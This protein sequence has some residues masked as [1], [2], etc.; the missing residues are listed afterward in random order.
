[1]EPFSSTLQKSHGISTIEGLQL[2][3]LEEKAFKVDTVVDV[4]EPV[5]TAAR[6]PSPAERAA[7]Q[8][9]QRER[10]EAVHSLVQAVIAHPGL[11]KNHYTINGA[12]HDDIFTQSQID[13][14]RDTSKVSALI[15]WFI[16]EACK[17]SAHRNLG[18]LK[19]FDGSFTCSPSR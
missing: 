11:M 18:F 10:A 16:A 17:A 5:A 19:E 9:S 15:P 14:D 2:Q 1:M 6:P 13:V 3:A 12:S 4:D 8:A 7:Q